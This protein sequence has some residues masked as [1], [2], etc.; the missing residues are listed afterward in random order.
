[1]LINFWDQNHPHSK[2]SLQWIHTLQSRQL[3]IDGCKNGADGHI[4][5]GTL[6]RDSNEQL[7]A[8]FTENLGRGQ[9]LEAELWG[10]FLPYKTGLGKWL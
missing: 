10:D 9:V 3:D 2:S 7:S 5:A 4:G 1:M 6:I 8:G